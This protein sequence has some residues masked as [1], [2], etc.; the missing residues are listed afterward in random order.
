LWPADDAAP[1]APVL[2]LVAFEV[3]LPLEPQAAITT[4]A[5]AISSTAAAD[6]T[7]LFT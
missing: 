4:A 2:A 5:T 6:L 7:Y 1:A 3:L